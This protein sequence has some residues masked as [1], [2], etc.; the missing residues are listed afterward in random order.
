MLADRSQ[1]PLRSSTQQ[2]T[3][4]DAMNDPQPNNGW[5]LGTLMEEL[6]EGLK[7]LKGIGTPQEHQQS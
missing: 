1:G 4:T 7:T 2:L 3:E 5:R 6:E